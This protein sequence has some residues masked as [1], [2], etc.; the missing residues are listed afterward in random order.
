MYLFPRQDAP[1]T[2][3]PPGVTPNYTNPDSIGPRILVA[4]PLLG[5][6]A[7]IFLVFR[8]TIKTRVLG[9]WGMDDTFIVI[10]TCFAIARV[11]FNILIVAKYMTGR[12]TWDIP[13]EELVHI[14][15]GGKNGLFIGDMIYFWGIMF[16]KLSI[17]TLYRN[18][19]KVHRRF[20]FLVYVMMALVVS[21]CLIF[22]FITAFDCNPVAKN[23]HLIGWSGGGTCVDMIK[24]NYAAGGI[25][26][27]TDTAI[28]VMP[29][30]LIVRLHLDK[31]RKIGLLAIFA[32][33]LFVVACSVIRQ[34]VI[35]KTF[36]DFDQNRSVVGQII[37][38]T[39]EL[40]VG[41]VCASMPSLAPLYTRRIVHNM[42]PES[43]RSYFSRSKGS[44][45]ISKRPSSNRS[46]EFGSQ[47]LDSRSNIELVEDVQ[48]TVKGNATQKVF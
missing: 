19:F 1:P 21:Y 46:T 40:C 4:C 3:A 32:T 27:F 26:I 5:A 43:W 28:L 8:V 42:V 13:P 33:G 16:T 38:L 17:L 47:L 20:R 7:L 9:M 14:G 45:G 12:H 15:N 44:T 18:V 22:F 34:I 31:V 41:I 30:P 37:W 2:L 25:N 10:A 29:L 35:V 23:W 39:A 24:I 48:A 36:K 11:A 6:L